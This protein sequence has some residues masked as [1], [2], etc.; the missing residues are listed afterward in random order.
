M[1]HEN[2][3]V[4]SRKQIYY[5]LFKDESLIIAPE[6]EDIWKDIV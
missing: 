6:C 5:F 3:P 2:F 1:F 4:L